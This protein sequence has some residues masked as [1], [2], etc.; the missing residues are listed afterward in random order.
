MTPINVAQ[1]IMDVM[2]VHITFKE[3]VHTETE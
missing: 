1:L 3:I 2:E